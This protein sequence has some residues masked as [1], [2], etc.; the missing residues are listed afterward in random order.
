MPGGS[1]EDVLRRGIP[2]IFV[3]TGLFWKFRVSSLAKLVRLLK[4]L[5]KELAPICCVS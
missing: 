2:S 1:A 3:W 5:E 4:D